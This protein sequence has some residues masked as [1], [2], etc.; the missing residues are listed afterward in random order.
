MI[1]DIYNLFSVKN[2]RVLITGAA[3]GNGEEIA[4]AFGLAGSK[5]CLVDIDGKKLSSVVNDINNYNNN[6][7]DSF[8]VDLSSLNDIENFLM[9]NN[10]F[11]VVINNAGVTFGNPL[12]KYRYRLGNYSQGK[13]FCTIQDN[14]D[15]FKKN[16]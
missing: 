10:D 4:R 5:L 6:Y 16:G 1:K 15:S 2:K 13:S 8:V 9:S 14:T 12:S 11:D 3:N 7:V